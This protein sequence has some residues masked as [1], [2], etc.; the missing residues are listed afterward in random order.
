[1]LFGIDYEVLWFAVLILLFAGYAVLDGFDFGAGAVHLFLKKENSRRIALNAIGPVWDGNEVWLVIGGGALFAGFPEAYATL[2]SA[3]YIPFML[4]LFLIIMRA[5]SIEFRSKEEMAWWRKMW[6]IVYS[7]TSIGLAFSL[8][9]VLGN[10]I[11]GLPLDENFVY[12]G[13]TLDFFNPLALLT[14]VATLAAC[15]LHGALY[16]SMKTEGRL[17]AKMTLLIRRAQVNWLISFGILTAYISSVHP[18]IVAPFRENPSWIALAAA[19]VVAVLAV[20]QLVRKKRFSWAFFASGLSIVL[21]LATV[22]VR[23]FPVI[24][25]STLTPEG[26][27][28]IYNAAASERALGYMLVV[29]A[30]G[31]PLVL[32]Y[33]AFVFYT[34]RGAVELTEESY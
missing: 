9:L 24:C 32:S 31:G 17:F 19:A 28:T 6:D 11:Q 14:G 15:A 12:Q 4:F 1:M 33:T 7:F 21:L 34:F 20:P 23:L 18:A 26:T 3:F 25:M 29:V 5:V 10:I 30:I 8:G 22:A 16:L 27:M 13:T 2:F